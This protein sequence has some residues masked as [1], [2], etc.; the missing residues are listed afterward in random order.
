MP[1]NPL[2]FARRKS[3]GNI[4]DEES[5]AA[6]PAQ[7]SSSFRVLERPEKINLNGDNRG[8]A[9]RLRQ[10]QRPFNSPLVG[11]RGKSVE[12]L[13]A[14]VNRCVGDAGDG[15][16]ASRKLNSYRGSAG[17]TNSGSSGYNESL[18]ASARHSSSSTLPSS[19]DAEREPDEDDLFPRKVK[20]TPMYPGSTPKADA[21]LPP[22][23]SF[24]TRAARALS[25]GQKHN[26]NGSGV[27]NA[28][29]VPPVPNVPERSHSPPQ[30]ER[31][32]TTSSYAS[33]AVP[34]KPTLDLNLG[35]SDLGGD[36]SSMFDGS[37]GHSPSDLGPPPPPPKLAYHRTE[38]EP[39][40]PPKTHSRQAFGR[41]PEELKSIRDA[42]GSPYSLDSQSS[43]EG[44]MAGASPMGS[45]RLPEDAPPVPAHG[46]GLSNMA[47][48]FLG[49]SKAG[50][51]P[52]SDRTSPGFDSR[53]S[54]DSQNGYSGSDVNDEADNY[55]SSEDEAINFKRVQPNDRNNTDGF[56]TS[57]ESRS[58][59]V[60]R[61]P[62]AG[63]SNASPAT[64]A[65]NGMLSQASAGASRS[66][67]MSPASSEGGGSLWESS[68]TT[69]RAATAKLSNSETTFDSSPVGPPSRALR[70]QHMR[71][72]S[73][74]LKKMTKEQFE[75]LQRGG[76]SSADQSDEDD[77]SADEYDAED[78]ADRAKRLARQRQKQEANMSVYRQQMKKVT[79]GGPADLP[80]AARP[81]MDRAAAS[82]PAAAGLLHF[83]GIGGQPPPDSVRGKQT[84]D[85][86]EDVPLGILQAHGFPSSSRPPTRQGENDLG[87]Q[88][89][90]SSATSIAGG[91]A[92]QGNLPPF[93]RRLPQDPYFGASVVNQPQ[94]ES[95]GM[96]GAASV[97]GG[98]SMMQ[99][100]QPMM[101]PQQQQMGHPGGLVGIIAGEERAKAARRGSPNPATGAFPGA[102][103]NPGM[104]MGRSMTMGNLQPPQTYMPSGG[105]MPQM[106]MMPGMP[107]MPPMP[108]MPSTPDPQQE[109]MKQFMQMQMQFMQNMMEMQSRQLGQTPPPQTPSPDFLGVPMQGSRQSM[110]SQAGPGT[111]S[112][113]S[114]APPYQGRAMTMTH[115]PTRW[116]VPPGAQRP[117][118]AMPTTYAPSGMNVPGAGPGPGYAP[119]I[120]PS[121]RSNVGMPSRYRPVT[122]GG[123]DGMG[124]SQT[125]TSSLTVNPYAP[126]HQQ[127][128]LS[129][130]V[131]QQPPPEQRKS[132]MIRL[133]EKQKGAPRVMAKQVQADEEEEEG[134]AEMKKRRER[135]KFGFGRKKDNGVEGLYQEYE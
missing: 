86:D 108:M 118:S 4:L 58:A 103:A 25:W 87:H 30:R 48:A 106:P 59:T 97:Y 127:Q 62:L 76:P 11:L 113:R 66:G 94:R 124:R 55:S 126:Q 74:T 8:A 78:D 46:S 37:K 69:P 15:Y 10:V 134:W 114:Q 130:A 61:K 100:Q 116:D 75:Q 128:N 64:R 56:S 32:L 9:D 105:M 119:S 71:T 96:S 110:M 6:S 51:A 43:N 57:R 67:A 85:D 42:A 98:A 40:F 68:N 65:P 33:T 99:Q 19:V 123:N 26:R 13:T 34:S 101:Q 35:S 49:K 112:I 45:P 129:P 21:P 120:A 93:A 102:G 5:P 122:S 1:K 80:S 14:A 28:P 50:Y 72:E 53:M 29:P 22:P 90:M 95:L 39:M 121:E 63:P 16:A 107:P 7:A 79:G 89:R 82:A 83:G 3:S 41:A 38:S 2:K 92:G 125:M 60:T 111:P 27:A 77:N 109:Q 12:N 47:P 135:K 91:G 36:F 73:G 17:T 23:P 54:H 20:T 117:N 44:L 81:S 52:L 84:D 88:R 104:G 131:Q 133:V 132:S 31:A 24:S 70:P 115:L 18:S